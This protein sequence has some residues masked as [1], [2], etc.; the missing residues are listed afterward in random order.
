MPVD[1]REFTFISLA[2]GLRIHAYHWPVEDTARGAVLI[3]HGLAEYGRRYHRF[4]RALSTAGYQTYAIDHRGHDQSVGDSGLGSFGKG[5]W[6]G[7]CQDLHTLLLR[8]RSDNLG[9][10][11][12][13][14]GHSM[15]PSLPS[16]FAWITLRIWMA[17]FFPAPRAWMSWPRPWRNHRR[18]IETDRVGWT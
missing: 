15:A 6:P 16:D 1:A 8:V 11:T 2:D 12:I 5:A 10:K 17:S 18:T 9:L 4:A 14:F 3:A 13:L 7:L